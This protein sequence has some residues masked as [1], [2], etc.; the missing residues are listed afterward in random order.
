MI[1][2][3][4]LFLFWALAF[5]VS[6]GLAPLYGENQIQ[7][8]LHG[9]AWGNFG[10]LS[11][12]WLANTTDNDPV[13][14]LLVA[15]TYRFANEYFFYVYYFLLCGV[16][17]YA[18]VGIGSNL[19]D[20]TSSKARYL[21]FIILIIAAPS[22][23]LA[24]LSNDIV[25]LNPGLSAGVAGQSILGFWLDPRLLGAFILLSIYLFL[26]RKPVLAVFVLAL[27]PLFHTTYL[28]SAAVLTFSYVL[29]LFLEER[30]LKR[31]LL[32]GAYA[33]LFVSPILIY[34]LF[35]FGRTT[36]D[37]WGEALYILAHIRL[38]HHADPSIWLG[39]AVGIKV[40]FV[41]AALVLVRNSRAFLILLIPLLF[42]L[43]LTGIQMLSDSDVLALLFPWRLSVFLV[44]ISTAIIAAFVVS[45]VADRF[46]FRI[47]KGEIALALVTIAIMFVL[48]RAGLNQTLSWFSAHDAYYNSPIIAFVR[49]SK[50]PGDVYLTPADWHRFRLATGAPMFVDFKSIPYADFE[51]I[52]WWSRNQIAGRFYDPNSD[53]TCEDIQQ[54]SSDHGITHVTLK[55]HQF[56]LACRNL[57]EVYKDDSSGIY[58]LN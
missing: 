5:G 22:R 58:R 56:A 21:A 54:L 30:S 14:S 17:L 13:F 2:P 24:T 18:L 48:I 41:M 38:P 28:L 11:N 26:T 46:Q 51:V 43:A 33:L 49:E 10:Y 3:V 50:S 6:H 23:F 20:V 55:P 45:R 27:A 4:S 40:L 12:D 52:E 32:T 47:Y 7:N 35:S 9:L 36:P 39:P 53:I 15:A 29:I 37:A 16:Y 19:F 25:G 34:I 1:I 57:T 42:A 44:P 31:P 8:F